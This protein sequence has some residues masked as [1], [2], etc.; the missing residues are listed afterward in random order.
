MRYHILFWLVVGLAGCSTADVV[1]TDQVP[2]LG[3]SFI[4][5]FDNSNSRAIKEAKSA[6]PAIIESLFAS[7][8]LNQ[9]DLIFAVDVFSASTNDSIYSYYHVGEGQEY[10]L[11]AGRLDDQTISRIGSVSKLFTAYAII[12]QA[13][14]EVLS[15]PVTR[16]LPELAGNS[17]INP[18]QRIDW[19]EITVGALLSHQAG[20]GGPGG[21][22]SSA[23]SCPA[24]A[25]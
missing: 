8:D 13:G 20:S 21:R 23:S 5:N 4:S 1:A 10:A 24:T 14:M 15:H 6:F 18:L 7:G 19:N 16:Y 22:F 9:T 25:Q 3:P 17:T 11:S 12:A 2:L